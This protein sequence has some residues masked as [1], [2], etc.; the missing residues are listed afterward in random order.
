MI[1]S[2]K[3]K[4]KFLKRL[5]YLVSVA[6][7]IAALVFFLVDMVLVAMAMVAVFALWFLFF[8]VADYQYIEFRYEE[9]RIV[10]R[11]FKAVKFGSTQY[12]S[13][14]FPEQLLYRAYFENSMFGRMTDLTLVVKTSRGIAEYPSVS[15]TALSKQ[16]RRKMQSALLSALGV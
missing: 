4:V 7:A 2:N 16:D 6:I 11:Y 12:N 8:Q 15:L 10:L 14:E 9:G 13:I 3:N 5:F 1:L